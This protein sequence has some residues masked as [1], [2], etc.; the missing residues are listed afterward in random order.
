MNVERLVKSVV[1]MACLTTLEMTAL[2]MQIDGAIFLPVV[3][4][5]AGLAGYE[6]GKK[7]E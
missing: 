7:T 3:A 4:A 1:A 5:I 6:L 2:I